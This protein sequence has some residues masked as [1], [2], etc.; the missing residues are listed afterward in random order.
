[1]AVDEEGLA[2]L[3]QAYATR[4]DAEGALLL[5]GLTHTTH[6]GD[7][8]ERGGD[9]E[10]RLRDAE[11]RW[12]D[13]P[14]RATAYTAALMA[15]HR[16]GD[17]YHTLALALYAEMEKRGVVPTVETL[18][19]VLRVM[20]SYAATIKGHRR[21]RRDTD[22]AVADGGVGLTAEAVDSVLRRTTALG[23]VPDVHS[24]QTAIRVLASLDAVDE[25]LRLI[26]DSRVRTPVESVNVVLR[27]LE[28]GGEWRQALQVGSVGCCVRP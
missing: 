11:V 4:G 16:G 26:R 23:V 18:N 25:C 7:G 12:A 20:E 28:R 5:L 6:D 22:P 19:V 1:M 13:A 15:C 27:A 10:A 21:T 24:Y 2:S 3:V 14:R 17:G 9:T 8:V